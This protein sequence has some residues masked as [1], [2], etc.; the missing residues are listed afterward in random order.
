MES[1]NLIFD[2]EFIKRKLQPFDAPSRIALE[3]DGFINS[4]IIC[5]IIPYDTKPYDFVLIRR[6]SDEHDKH[7]GEMAFPGGKFDHKEDKTLVDTA[8]REVEEEIG[9]SPEKINIL[10]CLND[11]ITPKKFIIAPFVGYLI[12]PQIK[13]TKNDREVEQIVKI[14]I[15]FF[16][17]KKNYKEQ[18]YELNHEALAVGKYIFRVNDEKYTI[19]GATSHIIVSFIE[20]VYGIKLMKAGCRR[21]RCE[22]L[23]RK[24]GELE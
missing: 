19:F 22:D 11:H 7:S 16:T 20:Q 18:T 6:T 21:L 1:L 4:A 12:D 15:S 2:E 9:I 23:N 8:L 5:L 24:S 13:M 14:P 3:Y 10:G 17:N